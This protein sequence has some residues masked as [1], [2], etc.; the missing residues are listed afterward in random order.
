MG[1]ET[2]ESWIV[3]GWCGRV[4][5][6]YGDDRDIDTKDSTTRGEVVAEGCERGEKEKVI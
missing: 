2:W 5:R 1:T 6:H 3:P 4:F